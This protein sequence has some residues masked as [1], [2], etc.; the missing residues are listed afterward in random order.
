MIR[1]TL[2][3]LLLALTLS[4][5]TVKDYRQ[6]NYDKLELE[7]VDRLVNLNGGYPEETIKVVIRNIGDDPTKTYYHVVPTNISNAIADIKF[8]AANDLKYSVIQVRG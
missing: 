3:I 2:V 5:L 4:E 8:V 7:K 6:F 1:I